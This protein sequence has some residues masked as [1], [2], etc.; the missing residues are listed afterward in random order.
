MEFLAGADRTVLD[1][2]AQS[3]KHKVEEVVYS[4]KCDQDRP[5]NGNTISLDMRGR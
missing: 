4:K 5:S 1:V 3:H 2:V